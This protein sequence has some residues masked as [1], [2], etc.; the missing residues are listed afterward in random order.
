MKVNCVVNLLNLRKG[1]IPNDKITYYAQFYRKLYRQSHR[2]TKEDYLGPNMC[3][4]YQPA[5]STNLD[6]QSTSSW[7]IEDQLRQPILYNFVGLCE[8]T[9]SAHVRDG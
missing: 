1:P 7:A 2:L 4:F 3:K 6:E 5:M 8:S 9:F